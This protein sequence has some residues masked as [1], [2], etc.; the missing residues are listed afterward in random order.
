M[1]QTD[2]LTRKFPY[3]A[4]LPAADATALRHAPI[5]IGRL[6][7]GTVL[8]WSL[9][10]LVA[11]LLGNG[12]MTAAFPLLGFFLLPL[13]GDVVVYLLTITLLQ[14]LSAIAR[15]PAYRQ[16]LWLQAKAVLRLTTELHATAT[17]SPRQQPAYWRISRPQPQQQ[18]WLALRQRLI[19]PALV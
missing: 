15:T 1:N 6:G 3:L 5:I 17:S 12:I 8:L 10:L 14:Q 16:L 4:P 18:R 19:F 13:I 11:A 7:L 2:T 9:T